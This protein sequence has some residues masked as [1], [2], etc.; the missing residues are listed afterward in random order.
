MFK[1][2]FEVGKAALR[3]GVD[4]QKY[5][6]GVMEDLGNTVPQAITLV[7]TEAMKA[8]VEA[9]PELDSLLAEAKASAEETDKAGKTLVKRVKKAW[10]SSPIS[11]EQ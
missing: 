9:K 8:F 7:K 2:I 6:G 3:A 1:S 5:I 4:Y 11:Q 10:K